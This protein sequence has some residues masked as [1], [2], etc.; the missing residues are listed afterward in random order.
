MP[1]A[2]SRPVMTGAGAKHLIG[3]RQTFQNSDKQEI[4]RLQKGERQQ[5]LA[6]GAVAQNR[7]LHILR[8]R[9]H[10]RGHHHRPG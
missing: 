1:D 3:D 6:F 7:N 8:Q 4:K 2:L 10:H 5:R 9:H